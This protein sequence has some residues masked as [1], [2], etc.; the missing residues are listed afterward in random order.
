MLSTPRALALS[1]LIAGVALPLLAQPT[2]SAYQA[3]IANTT[4]S[5]A[6]ATFFTC[7]AAYLNRSASILFSYPMTE[8][9][10]S[11]AANDS[12]GK[13]VSGI[14]TGTM[15]S[16]TDARTACP[17][18]VPAN[19]YLLNGTSSYLTANSKATAPASFAAE[20]WF[21]TGAA[22]TG[23]L[24]GFGSSQT[25]ASTKHDR[26]VF[27]NTSGQ[28]AFFVNPGTGATITGAQ[29]LRDGNWHQVLGQLSSTTGMTLYVDGALVASNSVTKT[30]A[31]GQGYW[32]FGY[33]TLTGA[34]LAP[35]SGFFA[36]SLRYGSVFSAVLTNTQ[37][38]ADFRAGSSAN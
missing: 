24:I 16:S 30:G 36:G 4:N 8:A 35:A 22:G 18:D 10:A 1:L 5:A 12:S 34:T 23:Q 28:A 3:S 2:Q 9:S 14:Y 11:T 6:T 13:A 17:R 31:T 26:Q 7:N 21:K 15:T 32:R 27:I 33:D 37:I 29:N 20:V 19:Y 25:G 38:S